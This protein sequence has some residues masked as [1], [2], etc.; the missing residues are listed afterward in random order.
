M[1]KMIDN[2][3]DIDVLKKDHI[4]SAEKIEEIKDTIFETNGK[5]D[6]FEQINVR[7]AEMKADVMTVEEQIKHQGKALD[8]KVT[9]ISDRAD[10]DHSKFK[11]LAD[12]CSDVMGELAELKESYQKQSDIFVYEVQH[13]NQLI[14]DHAHELTTHCSRLDQ[15]TDDHFQRLENHEN[16]LQELQGR[17]TIAE[18]N[19]SRHEDEIQRIQVLKTDNKA[20]LRA[21]RK[22]ELQDLQHELQ[23]FK[24]TN[25]CATL[26]NYL[27]KY[28]PIRCQTLITETCQSVL[29]GKAKR[30]LEL[31]D[32]QKNSLL[33]QNLLVDDGH[34]EIALLMRQLHE[35]A[36]AQIEADERRQKRNIAM[37]ELTQSEGFAGSDRGL[38]LNQDSVEQLADGQG[39]VEHL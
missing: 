6:V 2:T 39:S 8:L 31:Y 32:C 25:H 13:C 4:S 36:Y 14:N 3:Q 26:D 35:N 29:D 33:Y 37:S 11:L 12:Q 21:K 17:T 30:R 10:A 18:K 22:L 1:D 27:E 9:E 23:L 28:L 15:L 34:G 24:N 5:L 38:A 7:L 20:F 16:L 19:I